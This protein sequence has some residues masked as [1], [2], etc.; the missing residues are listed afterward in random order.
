MESAEFVGDLIC[1]YRKII[2]P[3]LDEGNFDCLDAVISEIGMRHDM[4]ESAC[5]DWASGTYSD[6]RMVIM[7]L[8][9]ISTRIE[10][11]QT[12]KE[13]L[14]RSI[15]PAERYMAQLSY[16]LKGNDIFERAAKLAS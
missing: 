15:L 3:N 8:R 2:K 11:G 4:A 14:E 10:R 12:S 7:H 1:K 9:G 13:I 16:K 6:Y 5:H